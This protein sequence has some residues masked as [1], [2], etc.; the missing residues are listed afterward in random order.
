[1]RTVKLNLSICEVEI[2]SKSGLP[3]RGFFSAFIILAGEYRVTSCVDWYVLT[4]WAKSTRLPSTNGTFVLT[5]TGEE[6]YVR[7]DSTPLTG[8]GVIGLGRV[9]QPDSDLAVHYEVED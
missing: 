1:M 6:L 2:L 3:N 8:E 4:S 7:R 9:A 5:S